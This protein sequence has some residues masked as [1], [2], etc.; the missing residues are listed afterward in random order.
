M[1]Q[2]PGID[3]VLD[4][5]GDLERCLS[6]ALT[7]ARLSKLSSLV[8][9][10][11][12]GQFQKIKELCAMWDLDLMLHGMSQVR[13]CGSDSMHDTILCRRLISGWRCVTKTCLIYVRQS[14]DATRKRKACVASI[15]S[16]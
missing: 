8:P 5:L 10:T 14:S 9:V 3:I 1:V 13:S 12:E 7:K 16:I 4:P 2:E 15:C 6:T 11:D